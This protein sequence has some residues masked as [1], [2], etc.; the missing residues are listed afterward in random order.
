MMLPT[1]GVEVLQTPKP[2]AATFLVGVEGLRAAGSRS[3]TWDSSTGPERRYT[4][5][6]LGCT[7]HPSYLQFSSFP[8]TDRHNSKKKGRESG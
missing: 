3:W 7:S 6:G 1:F 8:L 4:V 2:Y 5:R